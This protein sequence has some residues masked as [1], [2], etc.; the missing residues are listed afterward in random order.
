MRAVVKSRR[1]RALASGVVLL[2]TSTMFTAGSVGAAQV[3][4]SSSVDGTLQ[5]QSATAQKLPSWAPS[6]EVPGTA[7]LNAGGTAQVTDISCPNVGDCSAVLGPFVLSNNDTEAF[8]ANETNGTWANAEEIPGFAALN[9]GNGDLV[10][11]SV[12]CPAVG[13]CSARGGGFTDGSNYLYPFVVG[14]TNGTWG[15]ATQIGDFPIAGGEASGEVISTSCSS[16]DN[17]AIGGVYGDG[18]GGAQAFVANERNGS[19][20]NPIEIPGT[21]TL[22]TG[23]SAEVTSVSCATSGVCA[24]VGSYTD[25]ANAVQGFAA[26]FSAGNWSG[27]IE[28]PGLGALNVGGEAVPTSVA[29]A[30]DACAVGGTYASAA[31]ASQAFVAN[32]TNGAWASA[33]EVPGTAAL[34]VGLAGA[35][36]SVGRALAQPVVS[37]E[38][39]TPTA[40]AASR[41]SSPMRRT[42]RGQAL[43]RSPVHPSSTFVAEPPSSQPHV[44]Q[45]VTARPSA[46][47]PMR[48]VRFSPL[49]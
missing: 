11:V 31:K 13:N 45:S 37:L 27:A 15:N 2:V 12:S 40:R 24:A 9:V 49:S 19:W 46:S 29:C 25:S 10:T 26:N 20:G 18:E 16:I 6:E 8:V 38:A 30:G 42:A 41:R 35:T 33:V 34:N 3:S 22:N 39:P 5:S 43:L 17:C 1:G 44:A 47:T 36:E 21:S 48:R 23:G 7:T 4:S 28:L 32:E 14:E